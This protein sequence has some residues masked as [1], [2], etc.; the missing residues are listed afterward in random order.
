MKYAITDEVATITLDGIENRNALTPDLLR[1]LSA[2]LSR[3]E[4]DPSVR[5]V[6]LT[7]EGPVF[8]SGAD[9]KADRPGPESVAGRAPALHEIFGQIQAGTKP[10]VAR[11]AGHCAAGGVGLA[12]ACDLSI[13]ADDV[14]LGF[15]EVRLGVAPLVISVVVLPKLRRADA[16]ELFL[17]G[18]RVPA[19][20]AAEIGLINRGVPR[21]R[22][23]EEVSALIA[24][25]RLGGPLALAA[26]KELFQVAPTIDAADPFKWV[27]QR[28]TE[29][30]ASPEARAGIDAFRRRGTPPWALPPDA[31]RP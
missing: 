10:V 1:E 12:A 7:N 13:A 19:E 4:H 29:L 21:D 17:S 2:E 3:A 30:F 31:P 14:W 28:S 8:C 27:L 15:T 16:A 9:L 26:V 6:V 11:I 18:E 22:L 5:V 25:L 20:R 24:R 23:D